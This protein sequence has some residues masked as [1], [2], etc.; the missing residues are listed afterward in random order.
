VADYFFFY[1]IKQRQKKEREIALIKMRETERVRIARDMHDEIGS[2]LTRISLMG[3]RIMQE[4]SQKKD[5]DFGG[6]SKIIKQ[7]RTLSKNLKEII[8]AIDPSNDK[9]SELLYY[10]RDYI[11]DFSSNSDIECT[12]DF[13]DDAP[14]F[15][16][17]S[18]KRRNLFLAL[19]EI[20]N[21]IAKH[22]HAKNVAVKLNIENNTGFLTVTDDG[23]GFDIDSVKKGVGM[24][25]IK[26]RTEKLG[27]ALSIKSILNEGTT[28][29]LSKLALITT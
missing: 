18:H 17:A 13:P 6:I 1:T 8:W 20:L 4:S 25:S 12:I 7:S 14:D 11:Y 15:E 27:G 19:K 3:E 24:D 29:V 16:V 28:I 26:S 22:A 10:F 2:G 21:N 5:S 9:F 23:D